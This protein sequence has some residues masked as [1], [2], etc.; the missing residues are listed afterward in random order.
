MKQ[1]TKIFTF[2]IVTLL[3][4]VAFVD[5]H[6]SI[7]GA[8]TYLSDG[9]ECP[10]NTAPSTFTAWTSS[11][12]SG[13][14]ISIES[15]IVNSGSSACEITGFGSG[16]FGYVS[17]SLSGVTTLCLNTYLYL[18]ADLSTGSKLSYLLYA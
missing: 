3:V 18:S 4:T 13:A 17:R 1:K 10:P 9:F 14:S 6:S 12:S 8:T 2:L 16:G 7:V 5:L 15:S 11:A